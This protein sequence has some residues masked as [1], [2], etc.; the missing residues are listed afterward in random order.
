MDKDSKKIIDFIGQELGRK[1][2]ELENESRKRDRELAEVRESIGQIQKALP[3][4]RPSTIHSP[5]SSLTLKLDKFLNEFRRSNPQLYS[6]DSSSP[7]IQS[8]MSPTNDVK[9]LKTKTPSFGNLTPPP[10][11]EP[12]TR[13]SLTEVKPQKKVRS[14]SQPR[15]S[16]SPQ[17]SLSPLPI[18]NFDQ[19]VKDVVEAPP[20]EHLARL[21]ENLLLIA[22]YAGPVF[23]CVS[24][25]LTMLC[26]DLKLDLLELLKEQI[27]ESPALSVRKSL[28]FSQDTIANLDIFESRKVKF[29][30][31]PKVTP[32]EAH[33]LRLLLC[34]LGK[35]SQSPSEPTFWKQCQR[36]LE[37]RRINVVTEYDFSAQTIAEVEKLM[38]LNKVQ[39]IKEYPLMFRPMAKAVLEMCQQVRVVPG[40]DGVKIDEIDREVKTLARMKQLLSTRKP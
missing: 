11:E 25:R 14:K 1:L 38:A 18:K 36:F 9:K 28:A 37:T 40:E 29:L 20:N 34:M 16:R 2:T 3:S 35:H 12:I 17:R 8:L 13:P 33:I 15:G 27:M 39:P 22:E 4:A 23:L 26:I 24:K 10:T 5:L 32:G 6:T 19:A 7:H 21:G 30:T 31:Q